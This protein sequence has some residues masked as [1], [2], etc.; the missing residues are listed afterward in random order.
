MVE[1]LV[2]EIIG[3]LPLILKHLADIF[4]IDWDECRL[5]RKRPVL[6]IGFNLLGSESM[7]VDRVWDTRVLLCSYS[8]HNCDSLTLELRIRLALIVLHAYNHRR[9]HF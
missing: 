1:G 6:A 8:L 5:L 4:T 7:K 3:P 9:Q 2:G